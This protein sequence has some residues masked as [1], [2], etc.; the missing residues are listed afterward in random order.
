LV[1]KKRG[2]KRTNTHTHTYT[3]THRQSDEIVSEQTLYP[4]GKILKCPTGVKET[5]PTTPLPTSS[6]KWLMTHQ[7]TTTGK[8]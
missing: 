3:H 1:W 5:L 7:L 2:K 6:Q 4:K 8:I